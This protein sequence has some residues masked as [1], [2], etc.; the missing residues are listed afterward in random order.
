M[1][2]YYFWTTCKTKVFLSVFV[3]HSH[4]SFT[5]TATHT[6]YWMLLLLCFFEIGKLSKTHEVIKHKWGLDV[7]IWGG[8]HLT[9]FATFWTQTIRQAFPLRVAIGQ[10][11]SREK[12]SRILT[13][14]SRSLFSFFTQLLQSLFVCAAE[15][16][17][18]DAAE[19]RLSERLSNPLYPFV[20]FILLC[21]AL[22]QQTFHPA[23][24][25]RTTQHFCLKI[26]SD[27]T[28]FNTIHFRHNETFDKLNCD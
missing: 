7:R 22:W 1:D 16:N 21:P 2:E 5:H 12:V 10:M 23:F 15:C 8:L 14:L 13:F 18:T 24:L 25:N 6:S 28:L 20:Q 11:C 26:W 17:T 9:I 27:D 19:G 4:C 3:C